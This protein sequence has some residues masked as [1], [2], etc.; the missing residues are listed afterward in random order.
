MK[1]VEK[2]H[3]PP[4]MRGIK[5][6]IAELHSIDADSAFTET[7]LRRLITTGKI[8]YVKAGSKYLV[9]LDTLCTYLAEGERNSAL[10]AAQGGIRRVA[11]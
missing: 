7:A 1:M 8:P 4:R 11:E 5:Q 2:I 9:N 10:A 6:A 3:T